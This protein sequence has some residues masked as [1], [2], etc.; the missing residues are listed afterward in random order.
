[1]QLHEIVKQKSE[2]IA[3]RSK[4]K[5][6]YE[7]DTARVQ[8]EIEKLERL[9][10]IA[11]GGI[12]MKMVYTAEHILD[13]QGKPFNL[14]DGKRLTAEAARDI[15]FGCTYLSK[16]YYGNKRYGEYYQNSNHEYG[17]GPKHGYI[18]DEVG[19]KRDWRT[20][21]LDDEQKD[22]CIYYLLNYEKIHSL[23]KQ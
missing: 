9:E 1:M 17:Y 22:A 20:V 21:E 10:K 12:D 2:R 23:V 6:T 4:I 19:L 14:V 18:V 7:K 5:D 13:V 8:K 3:E 11:L 15:A 16:G